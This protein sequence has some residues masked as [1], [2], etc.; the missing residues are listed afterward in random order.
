MT[1]GELDARANQV[2]RFLVRRGVRPGDRVGLLF[3]AA[4]DG[5]VAMLAVLKARAVYVPLDAAFP[6]DRLAFIAADAGVRL[7]L[8][9]SR[10]AG[11]AGPVAGAGAGLL[12]VD[13][14]A[15]LV[16]AEPAGRLGPGE[17]AAPAGDLC[18]VIYTSGTTGRPKGVAISHA[19]IC[20]F[21]RVAAGVYG[22]T[23]GDRVYQ[24]MTIA[25]DFSVEEIWVPWAAG[26]TLVPRP[27]GASLLGAELDAFLAA[28][29]VTALCCVPTLLATLEDDPPAAAVPAGVRGIVPAGPGHPLA[30]ARPPFP[31]RLRSHRGDRDRDVDGAGPGGPV[32]IGVPLPT[33]SAVILDPD[34][35][36]ALPPGEMGEIAI[37]GIGLA[38][39]YL[40]RPELTERAFIPDFLG[41]PGNPAGRI[42][43]TGD[44]GR[45]SPAGEIEHH[46][47]IDTQ[48]KI[49]GYRVELAEIESVLLSMDGI[50]QAAVD[51]VSRT[52]CHR[53][54]RLL[55]PRPGLPRPR[56]GPHLRAPARPAAVLHGAR[57]PGAAAGPPGP[58]QRQDR[59]QEPAPAVRPARG[60]R[61]AAATPP[62]PPAPNGT[63]PDCSRASCGW[64]GSRPTA[65][66]STISAPTRC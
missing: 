15:G 9:H 13:Q 26:A 5:Y 44:L 23:G 58:A 60:S 17:V 28:R 35:D 62:P 6:A 56:P 27:G 7:V 46:G 14:V 41:I 19:S 21:V 63:W 64:N 25:F 48:V 55:Q 61:P 47:R 66:S 38:E 32:T 51:V 33:Y 16:A 57:L 53:A 65:T 59:P 52:R 42:Y 10:L 31:E 40:N 45:I 20:N 4:V 8:T 50:A 2:A 37:A 43:R 18:Y 39:G 1:Y 54:G 22:I 29:R 12:C 24:G 36:R 34:A 11:L 3:D 30:P 49:R